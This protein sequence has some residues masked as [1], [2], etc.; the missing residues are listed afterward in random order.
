MLV[1]TIQDQDQRVAV[2][3]A[4]AWSLR[5]IWILYTGISALAVF[6]SFF[7]KKHHLKKEHVETRTGLKK[8][9]SGA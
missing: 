9:I 8:R 5:N 1:G 7:I 4:Y 6:A 3:E 2:R